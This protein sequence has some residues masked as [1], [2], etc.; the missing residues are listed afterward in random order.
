ML[1]VFVRTVIIYLLLLA[2]MR[3]V[4]KRQIGQLQLSELITTLML[5]EL[6]V[7]PLSDTD[8][9]LSYAVLPIT[10]LL[11]LEIIVSF[12]ASRWMPLRK[13]LFGTPSI[14]IYKGVLNIREMSRLRMDMS[15]L[16]AELRQKDISN[17]SDVCCA[18][19]EDN[20]KLSVFQNSDV[21][22]AGASLPVI[23]SGHIMKTAALHAGVDRKWILSR[24]TRRKLRCADVLL[25][26]L[27]EQR[28]A[29]YILKSSSETKILEVDES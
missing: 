11:S 29:V 20:G 27:D 14:L 3:L 24:L 9:P 28:H 16:L 4:G 21:G 1:T 19:L 22:D 10:V 26:S 6:A 15:E 17:I 2:A 8:V 23:I 5:S 18:I 12:C 25:M 13:C 7:T